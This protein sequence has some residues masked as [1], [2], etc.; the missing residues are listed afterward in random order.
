M[1][2]GKTLKVQ[3][4]DLKTHDAWKKKV[5]AELRP[6]C[7]T[8]LDEIHVLVA[9]LERADRA[10]PTPRSAM[11]PQLLAVLDKRSPNTGYRF[12]TEIIDGLPVYFAVRLQP[13]EFGRLDFDFEAYGER[14]RILGVGATL[15]PKFLTPAQL[16][17]ASVPPNDATPTG[18]VFTQHQPALPVVSAATRAPT[19]RE[20]GQSKTPHRA[21][22]AVLQTAKQPL[23][24][25]VGASTGLD[26]QDASH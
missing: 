20:T 11:P 15:E 12:S 23:A 24:S 21:G 9:Q 8:G 22:A 2:I 4:D 3:G 14:G 13:N 1:L 10:T 7:A 6:P 19:Q 25:L 26:E 18:D 5:T 17:Q 16:Q